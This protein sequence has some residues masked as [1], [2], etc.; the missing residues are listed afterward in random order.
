[1]Q[2]KAHA[3]SKEDFLDAHERHWHD[4][5]LLYKNHRL[6]NADYLYGLS[7]ECGLKAV[8]TALDP[9][10]LSPRGG[11]RR[12]YKQ[13]I[14][15]LWSTF[16]SLAHA[17]QGAQYVAILGSGNP[18]ADWRIDQ[19]YSPQRLFHQESVKAHSEGANRIRQLVHQARLDGILP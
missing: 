3:A 8:M 11:L 9:G 19:R 2:R 6:A 1:M 5:T 15:Q 18:F 14:D 10:T 13:H 7:A 12:K 16:I 4:A 17:R